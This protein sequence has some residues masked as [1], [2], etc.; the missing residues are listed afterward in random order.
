MALTSIF[1]DP[2]VRPSCTVIIKFLEDHKDIFLGH[3]TWLDY[4]S[5]SYRI[6]KN[7]NLNYH[8]LPNSS[9]LIPGHTI[10][11]SSYAGVLSS[12]DDFL[13]TSADLATTGLVFEVWNKSHPANLH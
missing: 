5:M 11:M 6:L 9:T 1:I 2:P 8:L 12:L 4:K 13:L 3:N 7:Y 10:S